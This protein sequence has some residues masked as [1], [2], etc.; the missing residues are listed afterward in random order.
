M[1]YDFCRYVTDIVHSPNPFHLIFRLK[2]LRYTLT[3]CH[4][5]YQPKKYFLYLPVDFGKMGTVKSYAQNRFAD[6]G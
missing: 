4:L 2:L 1:I 3:I 5:L 6:S